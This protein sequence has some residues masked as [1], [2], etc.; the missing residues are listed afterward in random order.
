MKKYLEGEYSSA[1][2]SHFWKLE[3][4]MFRS[5]QYLY[6]FTRVSSFYITGQMVFFLPDLRCYRTG[7][8]NIH[9]V[10]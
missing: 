7:I 5:G 6:E 9:V 10:E 4:Q 1:L 2:K 8:F 3:N